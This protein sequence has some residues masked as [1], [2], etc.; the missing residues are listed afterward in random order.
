MSIRRRVRAVP[1]VNLKG[2]PSGVGVWGEVSA[3]RAEEGTPLAGRYL[4][5]KR[6]GLSHYQ[7]V[8]GIEYHPEMHKGK[9][10]SAINF[11]GYVDAYPTS[12]LAPVGNTGTT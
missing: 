4:G 6:R 9:G 8:A 2:C 11:G 3:C 10:S 5:A 12:L 1:V 7:Q